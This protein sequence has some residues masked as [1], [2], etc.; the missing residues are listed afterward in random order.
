MEAQNEV[1]PKPTGQHRADY[2]AAFEEFNN[3]YGRRTSTSIFI[4]FS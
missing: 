4:F 2:L 1:Q 3:D